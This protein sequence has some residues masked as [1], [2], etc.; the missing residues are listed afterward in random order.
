L[1]STADDLDGHLLAQ[2]Y[3]ALRRDVME[4]GASGQDVR[5]LAV[6]VRKGMAAWMRCVGEPGASIASPAASRDSTTV[7][8][9]AEV[10]TS[11]IEQMLVNIVAAM[12]LA[13]AKEVFA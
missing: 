4:R 12:T 2:R 6:L 13:H 5:G 11:N 1:N 10:R 9:C 7:P 8:S 3:E